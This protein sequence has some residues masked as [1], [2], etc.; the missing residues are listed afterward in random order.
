MNIK[1]ENVKLI[2]F[3]NEQF[4]KVQPMTLKAEDFPSDQDYIKQLKYV[5]DH[6]ETVL[7]LGCGW[8]FG[9]I[10]SKLLG[11]KIKKGIGLDPSEHAV[12]ILLETCKQSKIEHVEGIVGTHEKLGSIESASID[13]IICSNTLDVVPKETS[14]EIILEIKRLLKPHGL[15]L[16]KLNFLLTDEIITRIKMEEI[17]ENTY[18][19]NGILRGL[20]YDL[21]TWLSKFD[22]F[23][24]IETTTFERIKDG[25]KDRVVLLRKK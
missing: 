15:L 18:Q 9:L 17:A 24:V 6:A 1:E 11:D 16:I 2:N 4:S 22:G 8:G 23:E 5:G 25:P 19:I 21:E 12:H 10:A 14:D 20:N 7:D 13:G 3:W